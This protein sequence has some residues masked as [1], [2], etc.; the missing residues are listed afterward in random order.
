MTESAGWVTSAIGADEPLSGTMAR[1]RPAAW[2]KRNSTFAT[3]QSP[4][5]ASVRWLR[6]HSND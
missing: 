2:T 6:G 4:R 3:Y 5:T 1:R